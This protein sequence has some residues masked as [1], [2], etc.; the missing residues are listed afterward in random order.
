MINLFLFFA[1]DASILLYH[2]NP[3]DFNNNVNTVFKILS[4]WF[5]QNLLSLNFT[6]KKIY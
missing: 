3:T 1:D 2:S 6:K 5:K 4:D